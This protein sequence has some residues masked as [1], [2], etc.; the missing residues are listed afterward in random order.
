MTANPLDAIAAA[1]PE[2]DESTIRSLLADEYGIRGDLMPLVSERDQNTRVDADTG[3]RFVLKI[4]N[5]TEDPVVTD[6]FVRGCIP[7][8]VS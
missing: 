8:G 5:A 7:V 4:A 6:V 2:F 1:P 3:E